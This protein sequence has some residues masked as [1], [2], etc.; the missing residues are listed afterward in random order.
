VAA[1]EPYYV[2][3]I[4]PATNRV[5]IGPKTELFSPGLLASQVNWLIDPPEQELEAQAVIR[6]RHPGVSARIIPINPSETKVFFAAPQTAV[7]PGQA[8]AFYHH[9]QLLGG[10][11][12]EARIR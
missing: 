10:A 8:V 6:Y 12:I 4:Q 5:V 1:R 7:A 3:E 9:D 11:W 2:L